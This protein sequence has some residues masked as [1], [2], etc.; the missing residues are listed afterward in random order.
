MDNSGGV[1]GM[2]GKR[3]EGRTRNRSLILLSDKCVHT[4]RLLSAIRSFVS[5]LQREDIAYAMDLFAILL[6]LCIR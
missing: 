5:C 4:K 6:R 3:E 1:G 2:G